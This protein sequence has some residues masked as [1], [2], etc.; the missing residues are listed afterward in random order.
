[1]GEYRHPAYSLLFELAQQLFQSVRQYN[2]QG[3]GGDQLTCW[4]TKYQLSQA[5]MRKCT[6]DYQVS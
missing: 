3:T 2:W 1:M 5:R 6:L 4:P